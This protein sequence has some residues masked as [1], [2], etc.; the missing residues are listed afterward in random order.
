MKTS[1]LLIVSLF[2]TMGFAACS[3]SEPETVDQTS[4]PAV[5]EPGPPAP[6]VAEARPPAEQFLAG[7]LTEIDL[8][9]KTLVLK[10]TQGNAHSIAFSETTKLTGGGGARDLRG[11]EGHNATIR[12]VEMNNLKSAVQIHVEL[13]S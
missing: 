3:G 13:G 11:Q 4:L 6:L 10:D 8:D 1:Y 7:Q 5:Q 9:G 2:C 12:Y